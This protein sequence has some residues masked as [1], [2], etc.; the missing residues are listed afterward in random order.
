MLTREMHQPTM[1]RKNARR[2][3]DV[4]SRTPSTLAHSRRGPAVFEN[5]GEGLVPT[6]RH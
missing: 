3:L 1:L 2:A 4:F 6:Q 5:R